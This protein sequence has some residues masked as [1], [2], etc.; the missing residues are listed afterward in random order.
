MKNTYLI[1]R[2]LYA[3]AKWERTR[4]KCFDRDGHRCRQC[5]SAGRLECDHILNM[6]SLIKLH[7]LR[8]ADM[9]QIEALFFDLDRV[10]TLCRGCHIVKTRFEL[11]CSTPERR[12][13]QEYINT[14]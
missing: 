5:G 13:W 9:W 2:G 3:S 1:Y 12:A 6:T 7:N 14:L 11:S 8:A 4:R 10:Q